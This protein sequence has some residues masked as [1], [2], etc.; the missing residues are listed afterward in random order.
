MWINVQHISVV[1]NKYNELVT[2]F[3]RDFYIKLSSNNIIFIV[4]LEILYLLRDAT[5]PC[6]SGRCKWFCILFNM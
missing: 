2:I 1:I 4:K 3:I 5:F 6:F